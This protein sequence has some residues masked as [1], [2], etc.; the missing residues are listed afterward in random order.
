MDAIVHLLIYLVI[1][2]IIFGLLFYLLQIAPIP[3]PWIWFALVALIVV[4]II[5]FLLNLIGPMPSINIGGGH[6]GR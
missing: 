2:G 4:F 6:G 1:A 3:E 5:Y